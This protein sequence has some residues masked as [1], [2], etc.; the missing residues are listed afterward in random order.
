LGGLLAVYFLIPKGGEEIL[1]RRARSIDFDPEPIKNNQPIRIQNSTN[2]AN[3][4][5]GDPICTTGI[6]FYFI[7][8]TTLHKGTMT[9]FLGQSSTIF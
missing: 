1:S 6:D 9:H 8:G 7:K 3:L 2:D 5:N 4:S